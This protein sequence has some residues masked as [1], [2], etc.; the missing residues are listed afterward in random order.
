MFINLGIFSLHLPANFLKLVEDL[1]K[2][3]NPW[4]EQTQP[5]T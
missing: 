5:N 4:H 1:D 3:Q 2:T